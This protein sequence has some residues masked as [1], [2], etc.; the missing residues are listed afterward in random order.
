[1]QI[2]PLTNLPARPIIPII[3]TGNDGNLPAFA[4]QRGRIT[5][6]KSSRSGRRSKHHPRAAHRGAARSLGWDGSARYSGN[7]AA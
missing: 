6:C 2:L 5:G 3:Q 1:M 7:E 4:D